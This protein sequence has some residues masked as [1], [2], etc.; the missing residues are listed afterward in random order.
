MHSGA[1]L[2]PIW[3]RSP[4]LGARKLAPK[5][6]FSCEKQTCICYKKTFIYIKVNLKGLKESHFKLFLALALASGAT[7]ARLGVSEHPPNPH[8]QR[9]KI[10]LCGYRCPSYFSRS[11]PEDSILIYV[12]AINDASSNKWE[13]F[14]KHSRSQ[15]LFEFA[16]ARNITDVKLFNP[17]SAVPYTSIKIQV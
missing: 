10:D 2:G 4:L 3:K 6:P 1:D 11:A 16:V 9:L 8:F 5:K 13:R 15:E 7:R 14:P 12:K 17:Y